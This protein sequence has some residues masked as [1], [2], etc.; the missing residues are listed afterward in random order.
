VPAQRPLPAGP[1]TV[2]AF[3]GD[4]FFGSSD[5]GATWKRRSSD[6]GGTMI[7]A[8]DPHHPSTIYGVYFDG[9]A[10]ELIGTADGGRD[11]RQLAVPYGCGGDSICEVDM[12]AFAIDPENPDTI[13][14]G[15]SYFYHFGGSGDFLLRSDDAFSTYQ[16]LATPPG[17][18]ALVVDPRDSAVLFGLTYSGLFKSNHA[19]ASWL[20]TG[21]GL[22][23]S[24]SAPVL[25]IDPKNPYRLYVGTGG[26]G[27]FA[28]TDGG[29][30]FQAMG[31]GLETAAIATI[32]V[33]PKHPARLYAGAAG[34]GVFRWAASQNRWLSMNEG[35]P[36]SDFA[37]V[38]ALDP[39]DPSILYA[40]TMSQGV[41]RL[42]LAAG[43]AQRP[44]DDAPAAADG[45]PAQRQR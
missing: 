7:R 37:G 45:T 33:D 18:V 8:V 21:R 43:A 29:K 5:Q 26:Q 38:L 23:V 36:V 4:G 27:I 39:Q 34:S 35:L 2:V 17:L 11:W 31:R 6:F 3:A 22:P 14:V 30:H 13:Y 24:L 42:N 19:G 41:F 9:Q 10:D 1:D 25:A 20:P 40:G 12:P 16:E 32:L 15:G 28:S 44:G